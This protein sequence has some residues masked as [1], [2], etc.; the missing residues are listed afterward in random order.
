[1]AATAISDAKDPGTPGTPASFVFSS[2][3]SIGMVW[4]SEK[5]PALT[6]R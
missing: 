4:L 1:M 5:P 3:T 6:V 2:R